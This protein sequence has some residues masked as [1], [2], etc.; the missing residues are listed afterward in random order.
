MYCMNAVQDTSLLYG[1]LLYCTA[2]VLVHLSCSSCPVDR[3]TLRGAISSMPGRDGSRHS[4][5]TFGSIS[6]TALF[7]VPRD[8]K[9]VFGDGTNA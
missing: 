4:D 3:Q 6:R 9:T 2:P 1:A 7:L 5:T 8:F